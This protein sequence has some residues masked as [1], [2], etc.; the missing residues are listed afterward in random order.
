VTGEQLAHAIEELM[1]AGALDVWVTPV[2]MKKGRP[3]QVVSVLADLSLAD[4]LRARL[5]AE[6]G[7]LGV[8]MRTTWRW[9]AERQLEHVELDGREIRV[10][11]SPGRAK[12][13]L[14][15]AARIARA[16]RQPVREV[17]A[18][19]EERWRRHGE[20]DDGA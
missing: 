9:A 13:E 14:D 11:V 3:G 15:D 20:D 4:E 1:A 6:T 16:T 10:K 5:V 19:A 18:R 17:I 2:L 7:S 8:R 12:A